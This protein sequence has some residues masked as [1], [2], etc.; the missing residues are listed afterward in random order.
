MRYEPTNMVMILLLCSFFLTNGSQRLCCTAAPS[1]VPATLAAQDCSSLESSLFYIHTQ[2]RRIWFVILCIIFGCAV[3]GFGSCNECSKIPEYNGHCLVFFFRWKKR[4]S[5][6][7][8]KL[9]S[10]HNS[11]MSNKYKCV[12]KNRTSKI[13]FENNTRHPQTTYKK[14][15]CGGGRPKQHRM[16]NKFEKKNNKFNEIWMISLLCFGHWMPAGSSSSSAFLVNAKSAVLAC[17]KSVRTDTTNKG[18]PSKAKQSKANALAA[19]RICI[20]LY[21]HTANHRKIKERIL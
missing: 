12:V 4:A 7:T 3:S 17:D 19:V 10:P 2:I 11:W 21:R 6:P 1:L 14:C 5:K 13:W 20:L 16:W 15:T 18:N 9:T 8:N